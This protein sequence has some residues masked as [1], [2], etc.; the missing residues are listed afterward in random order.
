MARAAAIDT[1]SLV[2]AAVI[3]DL[4]HI[5]LAGNAVRL[6]RNAASPI[7]AT[8]QAPNAVTSA[9]NLRAQ[10]RF[11]AAL[12]LAIAIGFTRSTRS[13]PTLPLGIA[14]TL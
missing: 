13:E 11:T 9:A 2:E 10:W 1:V 6:A 14:N 7:A 12:A 4:L 3:A 5:A 8:E